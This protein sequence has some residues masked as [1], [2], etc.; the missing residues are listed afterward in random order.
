[1][2]VTAGGTREPID[3]VR[4]VGNRS[5]GR[6]GFALAEEAAAL[7][8]DVTVVAAN[9]GAAAQPAHPLRRRR[10][11]RRAAGR[12]PRPS[13]P[14]ADVLLMAAAVADFRPAD[15]RRRKLKKAGRESCTLT[16]EPTDDVLAR[17]PRAGAPGQ[18]LVGFAAEHGEDAVAYGRD[19]LERKGLD[20]VVVNDISRKDIG[21]EGAAE[22]GDDRHGAPASATCRAPSKAEVARAVLDAVGELRAARRAG[23]GRAVTLPV[24]GPER[25]DEAEVAGRGRPRARACRTGSRRAVEVRDELLDHVL[26]VRRRRG[27]RAAS[28]TCPASARRRSRARSRARWT[29]SSRACSAPP[30]CCPPTSSGTNV[31]NQREDRFEFRPGPIFANVVLV[32]EINRASPKTQS[33]LLECMQE[34]SVTVDV[35]SHELARPFIVLATQNP[36]EFEGTYPLP[37]AQVDRFMA[38]VSLGYPTAAGEVEMLARPRDAATASR[39]S[40][41]SPAPPSCSPSRTRPAASTPSDAAARL[42]RRAAGPHARGPARRAGRQPAGRADA[43]AGREGARAARRPRPRAARRRPGAGRGRPRPPPRA[44]AR[45]A[46]RH[47]V[48][49]RGRRAGGDAGALAPGVVR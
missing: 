8:A 41:R 20:A 38:R 4:F 5:S 6:M 27:P 19:K 36:V 48:R 1:M 30:T 31:F 17:W 13:S 22:R 37:E 40:S 29:C 49:R 14:R 3:A 35:H 7:G 23:G 34:R 11:R 26:V 16:L 10:D 2:L 45:G 43:A 32:D 18:T 33:G 25:L 28:R 39:T 47:G 12:L 42:R 15:G 21:F 46:R 9:V 24:D 44:R